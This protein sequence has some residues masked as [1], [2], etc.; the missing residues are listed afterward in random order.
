MLVARRHSRIAMAEQHCATDR[1]SRI[2]LGAIWRS[3][4]MRQSS[5]YG[6]FPSSL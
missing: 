3:G 6:T 2:C 5:A 1:I 4:L